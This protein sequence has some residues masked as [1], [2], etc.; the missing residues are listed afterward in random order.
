MG[1]TIEQWRQTIGPYSHPA[2][3]ENNKPATNILHSGVYTIGKNENTAATVW[4][5]I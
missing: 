2:F 1:I 3:K 4:K 5:N